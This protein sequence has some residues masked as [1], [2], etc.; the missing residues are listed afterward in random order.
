VSDNLLSATEAARRLGISVTTFYDWLGQSDHG[1]F[2]IRGQRV[3]IQYF[4][5]GARGQ[6]RIRIESAEVDRIR[7]CMRVRPCSARPR[8]QPVQRD[9]FPGITVKLGRPDGK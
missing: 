8:R 4:Q 5:G 9:A 2:V 6:G 3:I 1:L 7:E